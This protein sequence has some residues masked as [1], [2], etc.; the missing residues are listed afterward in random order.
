MTVRAGEMRPSQAVTQS[1]PGSL[2]DLPTLSMIVAGIDSWN[3]S[4]ARRVDEPRLAK[5]LR[6]DTF[7]EPPYYRFADGL[8]GIPA[9]LF[10]RFLACPRCNRLPL[11]TSFKFEPLAVR[12]LC[13]C[14][15]CSGGGKD[16]P[17]PAPSM[18]P[19]PPRP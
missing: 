19:C 16:T 11:H 18:S 17:S 2:I 5:K 9:R 15:S 6:V 10:P 14:P 8:G 12:H 1:G 13:K 3:E 7:R 4:T